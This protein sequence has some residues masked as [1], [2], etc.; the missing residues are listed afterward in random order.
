[1]L[2]PLPALHRFLV[3]LAVVAV[4]LGLGVWLG[5]DPG[6]SLDLRAGA[7]VGTVAGL[8]LA[9]ALVH[10]FHHRQARPVRVRRRTH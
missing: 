3:V 8:G 7:L 10:D 5:V 6:V 2:G 9:F 1:M 4:F